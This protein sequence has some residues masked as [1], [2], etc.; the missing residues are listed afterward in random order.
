MGFS[1][2]IEDFVGLAEREPPPEFVRDIALQLAAELIRLSPLISIVWI[3]LGRSSVGATP[4]VE[5]ARE[6]ELSN[7]FAR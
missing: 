1:P 3:Q 4:A 5:A 2:L 6:R 7:A